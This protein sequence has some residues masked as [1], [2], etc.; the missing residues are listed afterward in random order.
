MKLLDNPKFQN[1]KLSEKTVNLLKTIG[2][3]IQ[4]WEFYSEIKNVFQ[5][6]DINF[7]LW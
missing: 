2:C 7:R 3:L 4:R 1:T 5:I 6:G